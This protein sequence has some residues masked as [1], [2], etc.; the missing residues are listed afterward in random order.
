V[1]KIKTGLEIWET[2]KGAYTSSLQLTQSYVEDDSSVNGSS[3]TAVTI[4][5]DSPDAAETFDTDAQYVLTLKKV[6]S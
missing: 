3:V 2:G 6:K 5:F 1:A 4:F